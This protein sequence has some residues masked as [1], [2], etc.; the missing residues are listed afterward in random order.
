MPTPGGIYIRDVSGHAALI[1]SSG[2]LQVNVIAGLTAG[3]GVS[4]NSVNVTSG[5]VAVTSGVYIASGIPVG[6][7]G[8]TVIANVNTTTNISGQQV[9][10]G[11]GSNY[12]TLS[13][14]VIVSGGVNVSGGLTVSGGLAI[15]GG[16]TIS[17][18]PGLVFE[19]GLGGISGAIP[20]VI[21]GWDLSGAKWNPISVINSGS[22]VLSVPVSGAV[23]SVGNAVNG[24]QTVSGSVQVSGAVQ[25]SGTVAV[26]SGTI[27]IGSGA[28]AVMSG[29]A[30]ASGLFL[31]SGIPVGISG[32][33]VSVNVTTNVS[34]NT[35]LTVPAWYNAVVTSG[36]TIKVSGT[37]FSGANTAGLYIFDYSGITFNAW[38][39]INS[40]ATVPYVFIS[41][42]SEAITS[43]NIF[44]MSGNITVASGA[45]VL[46][47]GQTVTAASGVWLASGIIPNISGQAV[48]ISGDSVVP[49]LGAP[50]MT[51]G[52]GYSGAIGVMD[53]MYDFSG[54][55]WVPLSSVTSGMNSALE[56]APMPASKIRIG[57]SGTAVQSGLPASSGGTAL[58]SGDLYVITV[59]NLSGNNTMYVGGSGAFPFSG[60][61]FPIGGGD[62][63]TLSIT[64]A[65]L[66]YV[67]PATSGQFIQWVGSQF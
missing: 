13:G 56:I 6:I 42:T 9:Y 64:N 31:A 62:A 67:F 63:L 50:T 33:T 29:L 66:V 11:S 41:G 16:V 2:S 35:V 15:S 47:S 5:L 25:V 1:D 37:G 45:I 58:Q 44:V 38:S 8:Q 23:V 20:V 40:G 53:S 24:S 65:N 26:I 46:N 14:G 59:R 34:G 12:V 39:A 51:S 43:G 17:G 27:T 7:S 49:V 10:L 30:I 21:M 28:N 4:G 18:Q 19:S 54:Q 3:A 22:N 61:G 48:S 32:Q 52:F 60:F 36:F 55:K 57:L